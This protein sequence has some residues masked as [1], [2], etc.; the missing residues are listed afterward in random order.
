[1]LT[2]AAAVNGTG[3][4]LANL[5]LGNDAANTLNGGG[6]A[7]TLIGGGGDDLYLI[8]ATDILIEKAGGGLDTVVANATFALPDHIE[9]LRFN[10]TANVRGEGNAADNAIRGNAGHNRLLGHDGD[11][12]LNGGL[13]DDILFGGLGADS[14][15]GSDGADTLVGG[16]GDDI[17]LVD[18]S[19]RVIEAANEGADTILAATSLALPAHVETLVL[20]GSGDSA[21]T[22][23]AADNVLL[24]N[25]GANLLRGLAGADSLSGG[26]GADTLEGGLGA[27][28]LAGSGGFDHFLWLAPAE[29]G[30]TVVDFRP[31]DDRLAFAASGFGGL[32]AITLAQDA[33]AGGAAQF[34]YTQASGVLEWDADG[35][36][37]GAAVVVAVLTNTPMLAATDFIVA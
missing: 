5:I 37:A 24:G 8:D 10:G 16:A 26:Q 32:A 36:G 11:D 13:G 17:F 12:S 27:D 35:T 19:D 20:L 15:V 33:P 9:V 25:G 1:V 18:A 21:G 14:L 30:D 3:N 2:G 22:G 29:G 34:V 4:N 31:G 7:D 28:T 6:R 23:N